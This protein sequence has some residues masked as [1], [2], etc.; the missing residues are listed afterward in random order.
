MYITVS[1]VTDYTSSE[2]KFYVNGHIIVLCHRHHSLLQR[3]G[4]VPAPIKQGVFGRRVVQAVRGSVQVWVGPGPQR[5]RQSRLAWIPGKVHQRVGEGS[6][7]ETE[8]EGS[9]YLESST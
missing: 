8:Y 2:V 7:L 4:R 5:E 1:V 6:R 3:C 9:R